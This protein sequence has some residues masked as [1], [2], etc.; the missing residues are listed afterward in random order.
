MR[1]AIGLLEER[2]EGMRAAVGAVDGVEGVREPIEDA[3]A[4][5]D[6]AVRFLR[7]EMVKRSAAKKKPAAEATGRPRGR[8]RKQATLPAID[9]TRL[10]NEAEANG[11][12]VPS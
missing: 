6:E 3:L 5:V 12:E 7:D 10:A 2:A 8:P 1:F 11:A 4:Q 9:V